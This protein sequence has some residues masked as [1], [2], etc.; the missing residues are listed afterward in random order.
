M[1]R[2]FGRGEGERTRVRPR[3]DV[4]ET[5][6]ALVVVADLPGADPESIEVLLVEDVL[7]LRARAAAGPPEGWKR[8]G[9]EFELSEYERTFQLTAEIDREAPEATFRNGRVRI[10]LTKL[11]P[12]T[13]RA[14]SG[15][16]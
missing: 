1:D 10:V 5:P 11:R 2:S 6:E 9:A 15:P 12:G 8:A 4:L 16:L 7:T 14:D 13:N 3:A